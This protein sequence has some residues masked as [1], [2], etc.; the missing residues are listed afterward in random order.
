MASPFDAIDAAGQAAIAE[1]LGEAVTFIG[2]TGGDY[3]VATDPER[4]AQIATAITA[5][6]PR[7]G[8]VA[9]GI[10]GRSSTGAARTHTNSELLVTD[11]HFEA[12][13]WEPKRDDVVVIDI[14]TPKERRFTIATVLPC[15]FGDVQIILSEGS[16][17]A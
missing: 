9:D 10:Q 16:K 8:K 6:S 17:T 4:P 2:M 1:R 5:I 14:G 12:L 7:V 13:E 11:A 15:E 3:S